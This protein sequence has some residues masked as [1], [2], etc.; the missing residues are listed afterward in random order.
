[1]PHQSDEDG[2]EQRKDIC[3]QKRDQQLEKHHEQRK[4]DWAGHD[5]VANHRRCGAEH[6]DQTEQHHD[7]EVTGRHVC[8]KSQRQRKR[9]DEF[10]DQL[11]RRHDDC[12]DDRPGARHARRHHHDRLEVAFRAERPEA[13]DLD[14]EKRRQREPR[15]H[16]DVAGRGRAPRQQAEQ[17]AVQNEEEERDDVGGELL[18]P[19]PD[20][21]DR[22]VVA[23][24]QHERLDRSAK[25]ARR[26]ALAMA[27]I[28]LSPTPPDREPNE[29]GGQNH[30]HDV[31]GRRD[32]DGGARD[33]PGTRQVPLAQPERQLDELAVAGVLE[34][35]GADVRLLENHLRNLVSRNKSGNST[36][37]YASRAGTVRETIRTTPTP[38]NRIAMP[39]SQRA[40]NSG[41]GAPIFGRSSA[42]AQSCATPATPPPTAAG[43]PPSSAATTTKPTP[44]AAS[45]PNAFIVAPPLPPWTASYRPLP[46]MSFFTR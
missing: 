16:R 36:P 32:V 24:E 31:L 20:V 2:R 4:R 33:D 30:E 9:L 22:D 39:P 17:V 7:D 44:S 11:D 3:L 28:D 1:M 15:G 29:E 5:T 42:T 27:T 41:L 21:R 19:V 35:H 23:D 18:T 40:M 45:N 13:G 14:R 25:A 46:S 10:P 37:T 26:L 12:H 6:E 8:E 34:D 43:L 38:S